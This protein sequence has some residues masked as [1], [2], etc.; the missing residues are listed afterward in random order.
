MLHPLLFPAPLKMID[1][2]GHLETGSMVH[3]VFL[4]GFGLEA[5][6][7]IRPMRDTDIYSQQQA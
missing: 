6:G 7:S 4:L 5:D 3:W 2:Q 1:G